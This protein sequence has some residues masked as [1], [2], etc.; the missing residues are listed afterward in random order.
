MDCSRCEGACTLLGTL[1]ARTHWRCRHCG[2]DYSV[3]VSAADDDE[4]ARVS[5]EERYGDLRGSAENLPSDLAAQH[6]HYRL[7]T[8]KR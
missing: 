7:G 4:D 1:G 3:E 2:L 5:F 8:P 6:D